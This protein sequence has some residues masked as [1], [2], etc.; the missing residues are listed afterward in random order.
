MHLLR[1][2]HVAVTAVFVVYAPGA[3][4]GLAGQKAPALLWIDSSDLP[5]AGSPVTLELTI[6]SQ[7]EAPASFAIELI[8]P[9]GLSVD[10]GTLSGVLA[11]GG[12]RTLLVQMVPG[13]MGDFR[14][15]ARLS[16]SPEGSSEPFI[17]HNAA[18]LRVRAAPQKRGIFVDRQRR[19]Q[20]ARHDAI[21][22]VKAAPL[23]KADRDERLAR[24]GK[25]AASNAVP[26]SVI[27]RQEQYLFAAAQTGAQS[28]DEL[29]ALKASLLGSDR[30]ARLGSTE[31]Y[32]DVDGLVLRNVPASYV[33]SETFQLEAGQPYSFETRNLSPGSDPLAVLLARNPK[34]GE[35]REVARNDDADPSTLESRIEYTPQRA[36]EFLLVIRA[37]S[38]QTRGACDVY[39]NDQLLERTTFGGLAVS[40]TSNE[41]DVLHTAGLSRLPNRVDPWILLTGPRA[42][43][44]DDAGMELGAKL[45]LPDLRGEELIL[46]ATSPALEGT[47][48]LILNT[49][50]GSLEAGPRGDL[51][52]D[53]LSNELERA[54]GTR[55]DLQDTD[56]DGL[57]DGWEV[58]G[59]RDTDYRGLG[60]KGTVPD[61]FV[62]ID[63]MMAPTHDHHPRPESIQTIMDSFAS[64]G[65]NLHVDDGR[66]E[67]GGEGHLLPDPWTHLIYLSLSGTF[68][69]I[70]AANFADKR[71][72]I[73][74]YDIFAHQ[75]SAGNCSSGVSQIRGSSFLVTLGCAGGQIGSI[76][77]QAG[78]FMHE[79]GHNLGL[80]HGGFQ[81]LNYKPNYR[82]VMNYLFQFPGT[83]GHV[84]Y[85]TGVVYTPCFP[86][87]EYFYSFGGGVDLDETCLDETVGVGEDPID[88]NRDGVFDTCVVADINH[89]AGGAPDG[90]YDFLQDYDD[91]SN[92]YLAVG[93][94]VRDTGPLEEEIVT[95]ANPPPAG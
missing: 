67:E 44:D 88:W 62:Q 75:Q 56:G 26:E 64:T 30:A 68:S 27:S 39:F 29:R 55:P 53:G 87:R 79:L 16:F 38:Q 95:C 23:A 82:S 43:G 20:K 51:D 31:R 93:G 57:L 89:P 9:A 34:T 33:Y 8:A 13:S 32:D 69:Q 73:Y 59:V 5:E 49:S 92:L 65:I 84:R 18:V 58:L 50:D 24:F 60:A 22:D 42:L 3:L 28:P 14:L 70:R 4:A 25:P 90:R 83:C 66:E 10:A 36:G 15:E 76:T 85:T 46:G 72:G 86:T 19:A 35:L 80:R 12:E 74:H 2:V 81:D 78:T 77:E 21:K 17:A 40:V 47:V 94:A 7:V 48:D 37:Y 54:L 52:G 1:F 45:A 41:G 6:A 11:P 61:V 71:V 91:Y 63:W